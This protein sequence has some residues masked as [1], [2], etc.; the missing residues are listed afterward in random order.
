VVNEDEPTIQVLP[1]SAVEGGNEVFQV[2][3]S[4]PPKATA[5]LSVTYQTANG[6]A[7]S[8]TDYTAAGP[9]VLNFTSTDV[10]KTVTVPTVNRA[11]RQGN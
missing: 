1:V 9:T 11:G 6:T 3:L 8:G 5:P 4:R 2:K 10:V 7:V